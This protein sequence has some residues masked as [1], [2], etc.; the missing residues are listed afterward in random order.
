MREPKDV[1]ILIVDDETPL[2]K[3]LVFDFKRRG[4]QVLDAGNGKDAFGLVQSRKIDIVLS[5]VRMPGGDGVEL[6][7]KIKALNPE[8]P[9]V[10]FI[11][12]FADISIE[13][14]HDKGADA[15]FAKPF[16]RKALMAA[17]MKA[18]STKEELWGLRKLDRLKTDFHIELRFPGLNLA[19]HGRVLNLG[20]GG[21][22]VSLN[23]QLPV[24]GA[25]TVF[26]IVFDEGTPGSI[27]GD[28]VVRWVRART[29][30]THA[31]GCGIEFEYLSDQCRQQIIDLLARIK[32]KS[33]IP[34]N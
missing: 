25:E 23:E 24:V 26:K 21:V 16:D 12:G 1:T 14:A 34:K 7:D 30:K 28:G 11:T 20:R 32:T 17:V 13:D 22:F 18:I 33:F 19:M 9:V 31:A 3:A 27:E 2:R 4:F 15:V 10:I 8:L 5:D 29:A 6:L